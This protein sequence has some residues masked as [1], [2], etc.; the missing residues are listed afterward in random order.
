[1]YQEPEFQPTRDEMFDIL[2]KYIPWNNRAERVALQEA[3]GRIASEDILAPYSLPNQQS[4]GID[5]IAVRFGDFS[6]GKPD[7]EKWE[8]GRDYVY[9]NT[10]VAIPEEFDTVIAIEDVEKKQD[11][12]IDILLLPQKRGER[13]SPVGSQ[14]RQGECLVCK[15]ERIN[16]PHI[17]FLA[18]AG[19]Q[20]VPVYARPKVL[21]LPTGDELVPSGEA[22]PQGKNVESNSAMLCAMMRRFGAEPSAT[23]ILGDDLEALK[24]AILQGIRQADLVIIGAGSSKGSKDYTMKALESIGEIIVW[25]LGVAPGKHCSLTMV[26]GRPVL[27]IPGPPGG[28]E[29]ICQYY[30]KAAISMMMTGRI[31]EIKRLP[32]VLTDKIPGRWLDFMQPV[33]LICKE[34]TLYA[35]PRQ[36]M[37]KTRAEGRGYQASICYCPKGVDLQPGEVVEVEFPLAE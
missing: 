27:G 26:E 3:E 19:Y 35:K 29:L 10:G 17:G 32:A 15:G 9:S 4:S 25:Q 20:A 24:Q 21:F 18:A 13:V 14:M 8:L 34:N 16:P 23:G 1:M 6:Q 36:A 28:A 22:V 31:E 7:L 33:E 37:G 30:V 2:R 11:G 5:G 12:T